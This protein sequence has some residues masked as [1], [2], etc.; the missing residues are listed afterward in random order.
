MTASSLVF[1]S[2]RERKSPCSLISTG[3][4]PSFT[5]SRPIAADSRATDVRWPVSRHRT[6]TIRGSQSPADVGRLAIEG[7]DDGARMDASSRNIRGVTGVARP[8]TMALSRC[9]AASAKCRRAAAAGPW[10]RRPDLPAG[11]EGVECAGVQAIAQSHKIA[12]RFVEVF[13]CH[14][15]AIDALGRRF[16][17]KPADPRKRQSLPTKEPEQAELLIDSCGRWGLIVAGYSGRDDSIMDALDQAMERASRFSF[18]TRML[19][20]VAIAS[21][22]RLLVGSRTFAGRT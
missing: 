16:E 15:P 19:R 17:E 8:S 9:R 7:R 12:Q 5:T 11:R 13:D 6:R 4:R 21:R 10:G 2:R 14:Q 18:A 20:F 1:F 22:A 3:Q